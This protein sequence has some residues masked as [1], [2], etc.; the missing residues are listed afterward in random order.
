MIE[1]DRISNEDCEI[2]YEAIQQRQ[3][4]FPGEPEVLS[5]TLV[6]QNIGMREMRLECANG[7]WEGLPADVPP[8]GSQHP[9]CP[10]GHDIHKMDNGLGLYWLRRQNT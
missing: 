2:I 3:Q 10:N 6:L 4:N 7:E 8:Q 5:L 9:Q 1:N